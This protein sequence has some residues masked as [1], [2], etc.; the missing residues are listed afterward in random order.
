MSVRNGK[1]LWQQRREQ[2]EHLDWRRTDRDLGQQMNVSRERARQMRRAL[3]KPDS[4]L[5]S[6]G[7][8]RP[9]EIR[10]QEA[11]KR[12][13]ALLPQ[14]RGLRIGEAAKLL[15]NSLSKGTS[16]RQFLDQEGLLHRWRGKHPWH[17]MNFQLPSAALARIWRISRTVISIH[18]SRHGV[19]APKWDGQVFRCSSAKAN[20]PDY[21]EVLQAEEEKA[22]RF[23]V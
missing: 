9:S 21:R 17:L 7:I 18:R 5:R 12:A 15:E 23:R 13:A 22:R 3:G 6:S 2:W 16:V 11:L 10:R 4:T 20:D 1:A 14:L 19:G 8:R